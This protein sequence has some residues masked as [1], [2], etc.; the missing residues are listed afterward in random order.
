[1][2]DAPQAGTAASAIARSAHALLSHP[3]LRWLALLCLCSAYIQG[4]L[5][6]TLD[7]PGAL[8]EMQHFG[9]APAPLFAAGTIALELGATLLILTGRLR[10]VGALA[11][12][13]FTAM[14][15]VLANR[16]WEMTGPER[17]AATN[18]FF[19][20]VGLVGAFVL[21]AW[22]DLYRITRARP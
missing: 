16:F 8:G 19:E 20:H 18:S 15:T 17:F 10:W 11:L 9:L 12:A 1:M 21:V 7:W 4:G 22:F 13:A 5:T 3:V 6:K 14:A 2:S